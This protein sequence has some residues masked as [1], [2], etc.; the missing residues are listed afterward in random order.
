MCHTVGPYWLSVLY[1]TVC[2][3]QPQTCVLQE[4]STQTCETLPLCSS[5][6]PSR[7][8][9]LPPTS[10]SLFSDLCLCDLSETTLLFLDPSVRSR[11]QQT[12]LGQSTMHP[13]GPVSLLTGN[14]SRPLCCLMPEA[15]ISYVSPYFIVAYGGGLVS[16]R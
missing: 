2:T 11:C 15:V 9:Q 12:V 4:T 6:A 5:S 13:Q 1:I 14:S 16:Y 10:E 8:G 7:R 3:C